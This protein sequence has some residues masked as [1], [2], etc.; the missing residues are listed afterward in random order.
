MHICTHAMCGE[1][2]MHVCMCVH[3]CACACMR[4][5]ACACVCMCMHARLSQHDDAEGDD[6]KLVE[7][8]QDH[9]SGRRDVPAYVSE[10]VSE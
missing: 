6:D 4:V 7:I 1:S 2:C 9:E 5:H 3:V 8:G 10:W